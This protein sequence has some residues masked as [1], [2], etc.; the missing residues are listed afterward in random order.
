MAVCKDIQLTSEA[1]FHSVVALI[2]ERNLIRIMSDQDLVTA[3]FTAIFGGGLPSNSIHQLFSQTH[4]GTVPLW[5]PPSSSPFPTI[6]NL[7]HNGIIVQNPIQNI[8]VDYVDPAELDPRFHFDF[9]NVILPD[10]NCF[11]GNYNYPYQRPHG[12]YR[13]ALNVLGRYQDGNIWLGPNGLRNAPASGEWPVSYH[14]TKIEF[15][16]SITKQGLQ[17]GPNALFGKGIYSSPS[18]EMVEWMGYAK[19]F[20]H[21]GKVYKVALQNRVNPFPLRVIPAQCTGAGADY[22]LSQS[23]DIRPYGVLIKEVATGY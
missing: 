16:P 5:Q 17:P 15:V 1:L 11:R 6:T 20:K 2:T 9:R 13:I 7:A 22:W 8:V 10:W 4:V 23:G 14:G 3:A 19:D 21:N 18:I 12:W